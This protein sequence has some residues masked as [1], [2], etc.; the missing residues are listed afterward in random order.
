[1]NK[2]DV[3]E[4]MSVAGAVLDALAASVNGQSGISGAQVRYACG[5]VKADGAIML[6]RGGLSFWNWLIAAFETAPA[7]GV[8]FAEMD[9][10]L[11]TANGFTPSGRPA[12]AVRNLCVR[13]ALA[14]QARILAATTFKSR[15]QI[16][17]Y[18]DKINAS[19]DAAEIVAADNMDNVAYRA[20]IK[21]HA[22][23]S[24]DLANRARP[25]PRMVSYTYQKRFP[26]LTLAQRLYSDA[27]RNGEL[28]DE[29]D[30]IHPLFM[31]NTIVALSS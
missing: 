16:D 5:L 23:V 3:D 14:E 12:L 9:L 4:A 15:Q 8:T 31:P 10:V 28:I 22:A 29:N 20:L 21:L 6:A 30:P 26:A 25:L 24:N 18:F 2:T 17:G 27:S 11:S 19:F 13:M 1:M 7:A